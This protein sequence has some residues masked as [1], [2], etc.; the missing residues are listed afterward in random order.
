MVAWTNMKNYALPISILCLSS[1]IAYFGYALL[2]FVAALP[3]SL[4]KIEQT[5]KSVALLEDEIA[6]I[7]EQVPSILQEVEQVRMLVP[8]VLSESAMIRT[9]A[10][11]VQKE[12]Q[13][14]RLV[15]PSILDE[16]TNL[17]KD[18]LVVEQEMEAYRDMLPKIMVE[19]AEIRKQVDS[20]QI[21]LAAYRQTIPKVLQEVEATRQM[22]PPTLDRVD[23]MI[24][25]ASDAGKRAS[26]GAV[27][28]V[29]SGVFK[30][31]LAMFSGVLPK[32]DS[33][34]APYVTEAALKVIKGEDSDGF[35]MF[36]NKKTGTVGS[37]TLIES[38]I[39]EDKDCR[40]LS[41]RAEREGKLVYDKLMNVC[42]TA[43]GEWIQLDSVK[44]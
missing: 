34:D 13:A 44:R 19:T 18:I 5:A 31:P 7:I 9:D 20:L 16:S 32:N 4:E 27:A 28:G 24:A 1:A 23:D 2:T 25:E 35:V 6:M 21:E 8:D 43:S 12:M 42:Q 37:V 10:I 41:I 36:R 39:I 14:Y 40:R 11:S 30:A 26:E 15:L 22:I 38:L 3:T 17:R 33:S 29:F